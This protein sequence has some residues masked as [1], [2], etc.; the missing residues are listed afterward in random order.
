MYAVLYA[1]LKLSYMTKL[2]ILNL[3][4]VHMVVIHHLVHGDDV[5]M[6]ATNWQQLKTLLPSVNVNERE[7]G[8]CDSESCDSQSSGS[9]VGDV[10]PA[11]WLATKRMALLDDAIN[12]V[13]IN[14]VIFTIRLITNCVLM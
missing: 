5:I 4:E 8:E 10:E 12:N 7:L 14:F 3:E 1:V 6:S 11:T 9:S 2:L 13:N